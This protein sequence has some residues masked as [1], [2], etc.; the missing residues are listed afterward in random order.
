VIYFLGLGSNLGR[1]AGNLARARRRLKAARVEIVRASS[2]YETEPVD[3]AD[4]PWFLNQVLEVRTGLAPA[5]LLGLAKAIETEMKRAPA[6]SKGP[7]TIDVDILLAGDL[8]VE[9][10]ELIVPHPRLQARNFVLVPLAEIAPEARHP[11][12]GRTIRELAQA[13]PDPGR[14]VKRRGGKSPGRPT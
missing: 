8:V 12:L 10:P 5:H 13:S 11:L 14:V 2:V 3:F 4:Q 1:R 9:T 6:A 7:R